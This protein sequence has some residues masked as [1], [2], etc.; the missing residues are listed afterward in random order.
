MTWRKLGRLPA[1][2]SSSSRSASWAGAISVSQACSLICCSSTSS[3]NGWC[4]TS[5]PPDNSQTVSVDARPANDIG[6]NA[7]RI[8]APCGT[9]LSSETD[10]PARDQAEMGARHRRGNRPTSG[11]TR[12]APPC[13]RPGSPRARWWIP[14]GSRCRARPCLPADRCR[15]R[16]HG[17]S[18]TLRP[19]RSW[20]D[21]HRRCRRPWLEVTIARAA[22]R[23]SAMVSSACRHSSGST[24]TTRPAR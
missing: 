14:E 15:S 2:S 6:E 11:R 22:V 7:D 18:K 4:S 16:R 19:R 1:R 20:P 9:S 23:L 24:A 17:G 12:S 8:V 5:V 10:K 3:S 13:G 21:P